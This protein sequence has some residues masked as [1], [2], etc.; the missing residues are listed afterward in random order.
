MQLLTKEQQ[1]SNENAKICYICKEKCEN[2]HLK[3]KKYLKVRDHCHY[4]GDYR[5]AAHSICNL[6]YSISKRIPIVF[7]NG[8]NYDYHFIT[9]RLAEE[10]KKQFISLG[11]NNERCITFTIP[12][13]KE[14]TRIKRMKIEKVEKLVPNLHDKTECVINI[15][16]SK[17]A[18]NHRLIMKKVHRVIK[19]N[20]NVWLKSY[21]DMNTDLR[22]KAKNDFEKYFFKLMNN[23][24]FG[25]TM[26]NVRK[27][28][29]IKLVT[30]ERRRN[31][32][33]L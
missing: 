10:F 13:E 14:V 17:Q 33:V 6:K 9:K 30:T 5:G 15:R 23:A 11:E 8:S 18:L 28:R 16:N 25:K 21:I 3:D 4:T 7:H 29:E 31:Y 24:V 19:F 26:E 1:E 32:L 2:K 12:I 20:Q 27:H 22:K